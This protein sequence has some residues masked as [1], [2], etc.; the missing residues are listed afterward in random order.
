[1]LA[2]AD[3]VIEKERNPEGRFAAVC[4]GYLAA[5]HRWA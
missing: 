2:L 5:Q 3:E 4:V 1:M